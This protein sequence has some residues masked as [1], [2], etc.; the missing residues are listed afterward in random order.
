MS[1]VTHIRGTHKR[2]EIRQETGKMHPLFLRI[3]ER[4]KLVF[5]IFS[6]FK[7]RQPYLFYQRVVEKMSSMK[8]YNQKE[9]F[10]NCEKTTIFKFRP[11]P[12]ETIF[13]IQ[14]S[15]FNSVDQ[16]TKVPTAYNPS[17]LAFGHELHLTKRFVVAR[18]MV[19][20]NLLFNNNGIKKWGSKMI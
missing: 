19:A 7:I 8:I 16:D 17:L 12:E 9:V 2:E 14:Q 1:L 11:R 10:E 13:Y 20:Y 18:G 15:I 6:Q 5:F 3:F 4:P